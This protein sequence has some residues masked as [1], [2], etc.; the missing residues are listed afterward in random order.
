MINSKNILHWFRS[1]FFAGLAIVLPIIISV[2]ILIWL[3]G[4]ISGLTDTLLFF[5]PKEWTHRDNG[6]GPVY[7]YWSLVSL[8]ASI[9]IIC[10]TGNLVR[11]YI[12]KKLF[13]IFENAILR[14]P[15]LNKI[16]STI[17]QINE[18]FTSTKKSSFKQVVLCEFPRKGIYSVGFITGDSHKAFSNHTTD[19]LISVFVPTTPNPT[20]GFIVLV[21]EQELIKLDMSVSEGI[22]FIITLGSVSPEIDSDEIKIAQLPPI[23][24]LK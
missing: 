2:G 3:F 7:W 14:I 21:P 23:K 16:Y 10:A 24:E 12:G 20:T 13:L 19:N 8:V 9:L 18:A 5:L 17:K 4:T 15:L 22:K 1:N 11:Y 6:T